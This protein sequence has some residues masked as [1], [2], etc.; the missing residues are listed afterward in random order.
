ML[1]HC[2][3][4][5]P[6]LSA[7]LRD[8]WAI[9]KESTGLAEQKHQSYNK[10]TSRNYKISKFAG[11]PVNIRDENDDPLNMEGNKV[12]GMFPL[13]DASPKTIEERFKEVRSEM[14]AIKERGEAET[15]AYLQDQLQLPP[16]AMTALRGV[17]TPFD[18]TLLAARIPAPVIPNLGFRPQQIGINFTFTNVPGPFWTQYIAGKRVESAQGTLMLGGNLGL[19]TALGSMDGKMFFSLTSDP[20]L[21]RDIDGLKDCI[22]GAFAELQAL[23]SV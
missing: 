11:I 20:R 10:N 7:E 17:G 13:F 21:L 9:L 12:S 23:E 22:A 19:G 4:R 6:A 18:P 8:C 2:L 16:V 1:I 14:E 5:K 3:P 15:M